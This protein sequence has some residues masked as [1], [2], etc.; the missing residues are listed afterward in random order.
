MSNY[1]FVK[2]NYDMSELKESKT[3][4]KMVA[5]DYRKAEVLGT[6]KLNQNHD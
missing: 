1:K 3:V 6:N 5:E 2:Q 4:G